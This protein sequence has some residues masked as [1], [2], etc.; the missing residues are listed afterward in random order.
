[1]LTSKL[2]IKPAKSTDKEKR[3][4]A[5]KKP[6]LYSEAMFVSVTGGESDKK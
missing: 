5:I 4:R 1:M 2:M 6:Q 3:E